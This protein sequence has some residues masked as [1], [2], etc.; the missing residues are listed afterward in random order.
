MDWREQFD[1]IRAVIRR[2]MIRMVDMEE[3]VCRQ[4]LLDKLV[5]DLRESLAHRG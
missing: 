2:D 5:K 3:S 4:N 1:N